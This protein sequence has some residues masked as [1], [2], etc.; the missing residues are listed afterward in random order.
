[1]SDLTFSADFEKQIR[2]AMAVPDPSPSFLD[3]VRQQLIAQ[4]PKTMPHPL[5]LFQ[6]QTLRWAMGIL[7]VLLVILIAVGPQQVASAFQRLLGYIPGLGLVEQDTPIRMLEEPVTQVRGDVSVTVEQVLI[8]TT[9]SVLVYTFDG[10]SMVSHPEEEIQC[11]E[12]PTLRL[13]DGQ[14]L[15]A[16]M[17]WATRRDSGSELQFEFP[18]VPADVDEVVF[19]IPCLPGSTSNQDLEN[20]EIPL[21]FIPAP[22]EMIFPVIEPPT[23]TA[24]AV[25]SATPNT[26]APAATDN[27]AQAAAATPQE[28]SI[29]LTLDRV[30]LVEDGYIFYATLHWESDV[31]T[32][33]SPPMME[34]LLVDANGQTIPT[35]DVP[36]SYIDEP[37][38]HQ[39]PLAFK[40]MGPFVPGPVTLMLDHVLAQLPVDASFTFD[41]GPEPLVGNIWELDHEIDAAGYSVTIVSVSA[42]SFDGF[43]GYEFTVETTGAIESV[44][45]VDPV[46]PTLGGGGGRGGGQS[47]NIHITQI[48]YQGDLPSGPVTISIPSI[49]IRL[50][51]IWR[52][53]W[54]PPEE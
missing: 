46:N 16:G 18:P 23:P 44:R 34:N 50:P 45:L 17:G 49:T 4:Y 54:M 27:P 52:V 51:G 24:S 11:Q 28:A 26:T 38:P 9:H 25:P 19:F 48:L 40:A 8:D 2:A 42:V 32:Q 39:H 33:I 1:M 47:Q 36:P 12:K 20:W 35:E 21:R 14:E 6:R 3:D 41:A 22:P 13:P 53:E 15:A 5:R 29:D 7:V 31:Y 37:D 30:A 10:V 43:L